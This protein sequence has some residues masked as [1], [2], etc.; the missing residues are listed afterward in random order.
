MNNTTEPFVSFR[1]FVFGV[2]RPATLEGRLQLVLLEICGVL[3]ELLLV[4][5]RPGTTIEDKL[6]GLGRFVEQIGVSGIR[7]A[8][9]EGFDVKVAEEFGVGPHMVS[10]NNNFDRV[11]VG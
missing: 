5:A 10:V 9:S 1:L 4:L 11:L 7:C 6:C 3:L 2:F 8:G